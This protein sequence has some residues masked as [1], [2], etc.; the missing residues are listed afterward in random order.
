[1]NRHTCLLTA[2]VI[3]LTLFGPSPAK[4]GAG[5][6]QNG[7]VDLHVLFTYRE[8]DPD[9]WRPLF[10]E[11]SHL[12]WNA[13]NGQLQ[14]GT[15]RVE[16]CAF[17]KNDADIWILGDYSGAFANVF[18]LGGDGHIYLSQTHRSV[19][20]PAL[21]QFGLVHEFG[22]YGFG[23]YDE[24]KGVPPLPLLARGGWEQTSRS[25]PNQFCVTETDPVACLMDGGST[26]FP[27]NHRT[28]FCSASTGSLTTRHNSGIDVGG[29]WYENAQQTLNHESCWETVARTAGLAT[30]ITVVTSEP[31]GLAPIEWQIV[32]GLSRVVICIDQSASMIIHPERIAIAR[33][34]AR[35]LVGLLHAHTSIDME[36]EQVTFPGDNLGIVSFD[37]ERTLDFPMREIT[38]QATRDSAGTAIDSI[39]GFRWLSRFETSIGAGLLGSL[40]EIAAQGEIPA[41]GE[42][43]VLISDGDS[44]AGLSPEDVIPLLQERGVIVHTIAVGVGAQTDLMEALADS[45]EGR[46]FHVTS[47][48][49]LPGVMTEVSSEISAAGTV[50]ALSDSTSGQDELKTILI[51]GL[52]EEVTFVLQWDAGVL[53]MTLTSPTGDQ[54]DLGS[55]ATRPDVEAGTE[56]TLLFIRV[57]DPE[58][59]TWTAR[60]HP[61]EVPQTIHFDLVVHDQS[62]SVSVTAATD[63]E[64]Y[65]PPQPVH[66]R[67]NVIA[68]VPVAG[69]VVEATVEPPLGETASF[70]L[71]DDG[72]PLH[73]DTWAGDGVYNALIATAP[74][75]GIYTFHIRVVN[76]NGTGPDPNLPFV[77]DGPGPPISV[78]P[79]VRETEISIRV[80]E[81]VTVTGELAVRPAVLHREEHEGRVTCYL[82]LPPPNDVAQ[83]DAGT[84]RFNGIVEPLEHPVTIGDFDH[85]GVPDRLFKF[86]R[87]EVLAVLPD[88]MEVE[89]D[90]TGWMQNGVYFT[91]RDTISVIGPCDPDMVIVAPDTLLAGQ[92]ATVSWTAQ[93]GDPIRYDGYLSLDGGLSLEPIFRGIAGTTEYQWQVGTSSSTN[94][95]IFIQ[96]S[97]PEGVLRQSASPRF[98]IVV[99]AGVEDAIPLETRFLGVGPNPMTNLATFRYSMGKPAAVRLDIFDPS[100]RVVQSIT[101]DRP[102][103]GVF[104]MVWDGRDRSGKLAASGIYR[105]VFQAGTHRATG[106]IALIH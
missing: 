10:E 57:I 66:L 21:G 26:I 94:A 27:E 9:S 31:P 82:E 54:I 39:S 76:E 36:G 16:S 55:A 3:S 11:A 51:D 59:G 18:G 105:Y 43:I 7:K 78:P 44:N 40:N 103:P 106:S 49:E 6:I 63:R 73:G 70:R 98:T 89:V 14:L 52:A 13:T 86:S 87:K 85:D 71:F 20:G 81:P 35:M 23:L 41:C 83:I 2:L 47:E 99:P 96:A 25:S 90:L 97:S 104:A 74:P 34:A 80:N 68:A 61:V 24:Y 22:H 58:V 17:Q 38:S 46:F 37:T 101:T 79:F 5:Q 75:G 1:M 72:S 65:D 102:T 12:L 77:E 30:P 32:P 69:A 88:G 67:V 100:G 4:S 33:Q 50:V 45:T 56:G 48:E 91:A 62:R 29:V 84:V 8:S 42:T 28:E 64:V 19:A 60:M 53:D 92:I 93:E 15:I 95:M